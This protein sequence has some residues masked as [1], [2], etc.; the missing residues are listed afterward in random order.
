MIFGRPNSS[1]GWRWR[2]VFLPVRLECGR[3]AWI[4]WVQCKNELIRA[5]FCFGEYVI[6]RLPPQIESAIVAS[7][8]ITPPPPLQRRRE[9]EA[10]FASQVDSALKRVGSEK[11][12][13]KD[14]LAA[15]REGVLGVKS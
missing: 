10:K 12:L 7:A 11:G 5:D 4:E 14:T 13:D 15:I 3:W 1:D 6:W 9:M 2:F 8:P